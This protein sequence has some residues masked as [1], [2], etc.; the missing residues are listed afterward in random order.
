M[1]EKYFDK[2]FAIKTQ[3]RDHQFP[4]IINMNY[5]QLTKA[6][7]RSN[8]HVFFLFGGKSVSFIAV[9]FFFISHQFPLDNMR[10]IMNEYINKMKTSCISYGNRQY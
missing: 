4:L 5:K 10:K 1:Y 2:Y 8:F 3:Q 9:N 6:T 7:Q